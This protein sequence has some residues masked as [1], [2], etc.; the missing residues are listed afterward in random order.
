MIGLVSQR[1]SVGANVSILRSQIQHQILQK[2]V[3]KYFPLLYI[4][5]ENC[6][7]QNLQYSYVFLH[8]ISFDYEIVH[9]VRVIILYCIHSTFA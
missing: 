4:G 2:I 3:P 8:L 7:V 5:C 6:C 9:K 1:G